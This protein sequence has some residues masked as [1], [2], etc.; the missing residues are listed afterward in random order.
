MVLKEWKCP[1]HGFFE[2]ADPICPEGCKDGILRVFLTAPNIGTGVVDRIDKEARKLT[3]RFGMS[4]VKT[5]LVEGEAQ[6]SAPQRQW[7]PHFV[8]FNQ[9]AISGL[10]RVGSIPLS[11]A[12]P[13][14]RARVAPGM[15]YDGEK[16]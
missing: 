15:T 4:D 14:P 2:S 12:V 3:T 1:V 9:G 16:S 7:S 11:G 8:D 10:G 6:K 13:Q 5:N